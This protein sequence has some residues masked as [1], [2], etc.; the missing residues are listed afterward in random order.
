MADF[1]ISITQRET[2]LH[3]SWRL[4]ASTETEVKVW[5]VPGVD[6]GKLRFELSDA[7]FLHLDESAFLVTFITLSC[8]EGRTNKST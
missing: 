2:S 7:I 1:E 6:V 3:S 4:A 8:M 5:R